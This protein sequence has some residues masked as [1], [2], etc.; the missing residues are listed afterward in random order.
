MSISVKRV[1]FCCLSK[2][3]PF[4]AEETIGESNGKKEYRNM[5]LLM[6]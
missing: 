2:D 6:T 4:K 3:I 1:C 5:D